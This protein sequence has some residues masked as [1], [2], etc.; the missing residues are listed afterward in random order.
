V[1]DFPAILRCKRVCTISRYKKNPDNTY[2]NDWKGWGDWLGLSV[3]VYKGRRY[4]PFEDAKKFVHNLHRRLK[5]LPAFV[6]YYKN[7]VPNA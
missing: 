6:L 7:M 3:I 1:S 2:K 4:T 5:G